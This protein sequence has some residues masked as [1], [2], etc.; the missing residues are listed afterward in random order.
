MLLIFFF[1]NKTCGMIE[2]YL[3][4]SSQLMISLDKKSVL[5]EHSAYHVRV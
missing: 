4:K 2:L 3:I 5:F 1:A